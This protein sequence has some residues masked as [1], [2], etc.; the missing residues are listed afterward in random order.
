MSDLQDQAIRQ[1]CKVLR[2]PTIGS[3]FS[4]LA[5]TGIELVIRTFREAKAGSWMALQFL[6]GHDPNLAKRPI[7]ALRNGQ[8]VAVERAA[9]ADLGLDEG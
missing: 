7:D 5:E 8:L 3:Q 2:M 1:H 4:R 9:R 6:A